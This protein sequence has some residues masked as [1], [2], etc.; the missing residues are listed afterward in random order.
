MTVLYS[1]NKNITEGTLPTTNAIINGDFDMWVRGSSF[2]PIS[3][4]YAADRWYVG[5]TTDGS[6]RAD[7]EST[8]K[9]DGTNYCIKI[10]VVTGDSSLAGT[11][12]GNIHQRIE[13]YNYIPFIGRTATLSFWVRSS[14]TGTYSIAFRN[15]SPYDRSYIAE[16]TIDTANTWEHKKITLAFDYSGGTWNLTNGIG[17]YVIFSLGLGTTYAAAPGSWVS[18][19]KIGST[20]QVNWLA[21]AGNTFY[22]SKVQLE[23]GR[24]ATPFQQLP[25]AIIE[26]QCQRY[27]E[28]RYYYQNCVSTSA[29]T[30]HNWGM[31]EY[32]WKRANPTITTTGTTIWARVAWYNTTSI[33]ISTG[34]Q[35]R[36]YFNFQDTAHS[37]YNFGTALIRGTFYISAEL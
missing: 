34:W 5:E 7:R 24:V 19:N 2:N 33:T 10:T 1:D 17:L 18:E 3:S 37:N 29:A 30:G 16:Y 8:I 4:G 28:V 20:N 15:D 12:Y 14:V 13:G 36:A 31:I 22:L 26:K 11:Q 23:R 32:N 21:T 6:I 27:Y 9:P 35:D 25:R